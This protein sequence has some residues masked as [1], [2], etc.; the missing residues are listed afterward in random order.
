[1]HVLPKILFENCSG[2]YGIA[3]VNVFTIEQVHGLFAAAQETSAPFFCQITPVES[4][5]SH[6]GIRLGMVSSGNK[7][8]KKFNKKIRTI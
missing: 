1:M 7:L 3:A 8:K 6:A 2:N 4:N 5:Y